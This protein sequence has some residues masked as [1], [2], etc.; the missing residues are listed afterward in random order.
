MKTQPTTTETTMTSLTHTCSDGTVI[1]AT[2]QPVNCG[3]GQTV[4]INGKSYTGPTGF[5]R[6]IGGVEYVIVDKYGVPAAKWDAASKSAVKAAMA[7]TSRIESSETTMERL[8]R[9]GV[10]E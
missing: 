4:E 10:G 1:T 9:F 7:E 8:G 5:R 2:W 3:I 6:R